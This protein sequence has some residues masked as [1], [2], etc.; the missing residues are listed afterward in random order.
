MGPW[1]CCPEKG[2]TIPL[3]GPGAERGHV[4]NRGAAGLECRGGVHGHLPREERWREREREREREKVKRV[5]ST[6]IERIG[7]G[8]GTDSF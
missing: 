1:A 5:S 4:G 7:I 6:H 2:V 3:E 8:D